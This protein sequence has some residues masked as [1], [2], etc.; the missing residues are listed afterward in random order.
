VIKRSSFCLERSSKRSR[1]LDF[2]RGRGRATDQ[3]DNNQNGRGS[4]HLSF[5]DK[6]SMK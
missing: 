5:I 1:I 6:T 4:S 3:I 2:F